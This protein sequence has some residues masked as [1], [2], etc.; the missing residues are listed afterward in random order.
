MATPVLIVAET[1]G[2]REILIELFKGKIDIKAYD[3]FEAFLSSDKTHNASKNKLPQ[4]GLTIAPIERGVYVPE[5]LALISE[6]QL[7][8]RQIFKTR[9]RRQS[10]VS[11]EFLVKSVTEINRR[12]S[13]CSY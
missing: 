8:G 3:S 10:G 2:R 13:C 1:A 7:F 12:Q 11:E 4:V 5:R 9:R 6:T